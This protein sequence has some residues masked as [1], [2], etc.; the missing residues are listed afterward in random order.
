M[1]AADGKKVITMGAK[2]WWD[3][4]AETE[5]WGWSRP[6][7]V[8]QRLPGGGTSVAKTARKKASEQEK[9]L[10]EF[11]CGLCKNVLTDPLST[12]CGEGWGD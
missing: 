4:N 12:P 6:A 3:W 8:S 2:P 1:K 7:P 10:R 9:A 5:T 11:T